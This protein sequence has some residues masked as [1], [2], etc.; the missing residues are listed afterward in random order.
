MAVITTNRPKIDKRSPKPVRCLHTV[1]AG[2]DFRILTS[3]SREDWL[4]FKNPDF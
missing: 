2:M 3:F 4:F 1:I